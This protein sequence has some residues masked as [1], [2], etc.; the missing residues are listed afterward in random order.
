M[1]SATTLILLFF[2]HWWSDFVH[3]SDKMAVNKST[4][5]KWLLWHVIIYSGWMAIVIS[6][7]VGLGLI[8]V[9]A[10]NLVGG[11][12]I[13][14]NFL[15]HFCTDYVTSRV[16]SYFYK[17]KKRH[18]FFVTIGFDQFLH[19]AALILTWVWIF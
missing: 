5:N 13:A 11:R 8:S 16:T 15:L 12:F 7:G 1:I 10:W 4:S 18:Q 3:Q 2:A 9:P 17:H 19:A 14:A 6:A